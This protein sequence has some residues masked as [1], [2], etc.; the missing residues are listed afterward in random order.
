MDTDT[1]ENDGQ[2]E[3]I[4]QD[5]EGDQVFDLFKTPAKFQPKTL[6]KINKRKS[7]EVGE[8]EENKN[9]NRP[10][11]PSGQFLSRSVGDLKTM[12]EKCA[13]NLT[14]GLHENDH[15]EQEE[16]Q[17]SPWSSDR[18]S[19]L[20][21]KHHANRRHSD[22]T[23]STNMMSVNGMASDE[24][25]LP[26][27]KSLSSTQGKRDQ[28]LSNTTVNTMSQVLIAEKS[29]IA[30]TIQE[31]ANI[32]A[33]QM[34]TTPEDQVDINLTTVD[35]RTVIKMFE[36][37]KLS[38]SLQ[39]QKAVNETTPNNQSESDYAMLTSQVRILEAKERL[40]VDTMAGMSERIN[41][42]QHRI[43]NFDINTAKKMV[44]LSGFEGSQKRT[45]LRRQLENFFEEE[46]RMT[47]IPEDFYFIGS[48]T[49][50]DIVLILATISQKKMIFKN[51]EL[52]KN[53]TN[54][55]GKKLYFRD[56]LTPRQKEQS[57]KCRDFMDVMQKKDPVEREEISTQKGQIMIGDSPYQQRVTAPDPTS[58]LQLSLP[59]LNII[60]GKEVQ[61]GAKLTY[62]GNQFYGYSLC[63][64][65]YEDI[66]DAYMKIRLNHADCR[67]VICAYSVPGTNELEC[68]DSCDDEDYGAS[69]PVLKLMLQNA[70][71][72]RV[73]FIAR[74]CGS[75]LHGDRITKYIEI[76]E[77][78]IEKFPTN[79]ITGECQKV[80]SAVPYAKPTPQEDATNRKESYANAAKTA[81][82]RQAG[83]QTT[84][85]R[86]RGS[87]RG[88]RNH[89]RRDLS[90]PRHNHT[91]ER[92][93]YQYTP[94]SEQDLMLK[95]SN[96]REQTLD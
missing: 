57:N 31:A 74:R 44:I 83:H 11:T 79:T 12:L 73:I 34:T 80:T 50:R 96:G 81:G 61:F 35:M 26:E 66:Q 55:Q 91:D 43:D 7:S 38:L 78:V 2:E 65:N 8:L 82:K 21:V 19:D 16:G 18:D 22:G 1:C 51:I 24:F 20:G 48:S 9:K 27:D 92:I 33:A 75:K 49:P 63:T 5:Q 47:L 86:G 17:S 56:F 39:V 59:K 90:R 70:I 23:V 64:D 52:V 85:G 88:G 10:R 93:K 60:M 53:H 41:E 42:L 32:S 94:K 89:P 4:A 84:R 28:K 62:K 95:D 15:D 58:V 71:T 14:S 87:W 46:M 30:Q 67:H 40:M 13:K 45:V 76:A 77:Q 72:H 6:K 36:E 69:R 3:Q 25:N 54:S 37:L 29:H 68:N